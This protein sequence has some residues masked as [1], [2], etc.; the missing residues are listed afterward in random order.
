MS[1]PRH[2][3]ISTLVTQASINCACDHLVGRR[4]PSFLAR[5]REAL[6]QI[7]SV[8]N[9]YKLHRGAGLGGRS[10]A[11]SPMR[12]GGSE[13][14]GCDE[15]SEHL[16]ARPPP[17]SRPVMG[18]EV[19]HQFNLLVGERPDFLSVMRGQPRIP[20]VPYGVLTLVSPLPCAP[21]LKRN[22]PLVALRITCP[23][24]ELGL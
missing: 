5:L 20:S 10:R 4:W 3:T 2:S 16:I 15:V 8:H 1:D 14:L 23:A 11:L 19:L 13:R 22:E 7:F 9:R 17:A 21:V 24:P 18:G 12:L 6:T